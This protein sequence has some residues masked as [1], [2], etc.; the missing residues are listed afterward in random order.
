MAHLDAMEKLQGAEIDV[1]RRPTRARFRVLA[2]TALSA[3]LLG[4]VS[5]WLA[6]SGVTS[7]SVAPPL[8]SP[9]SGS[10]ADVTTMNAVVTRTNGGAQ[11]QTGVALA[12]ITMSSSVTTS[13]RVDIDWTNTGQA[14]Q[15]LNNPN[16]QISVGLYHTI[17]TGNCNSTV[18]STDAPLVNV[19]DPANSAVYCAALDQGATG[20]FASS[21]GKLLLS[22]SQ[23]GGFLRPSV[24]GS[25]TL[26]ACASSVTDTDAWCQQASLTNANQR[27]LFVIASIV[28]PGGIPQGQQPTLTTLSFYIG[29]RAQ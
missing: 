17:H 28:T 24:S 14:A 11:L 15:V 3:S 9:A 23:V 21:T 19:V 27:A 10:I 18:H 13:V 29:V 12:E 16:A 4:S 25:G 5:F 1:R 22:L 20:R 6:T 7:A 2:V 26:S 8:G